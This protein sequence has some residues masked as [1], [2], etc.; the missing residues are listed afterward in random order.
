MTTRLLLVRDWGTIHLPRSLRFAGPKPGG[1]PAP[2]PSDRD[3]GGEEAAGP[4]SILLIEDDF[5]LA[6]MYR[7][8]L[9]HAGHK[10]NIAADGE[11][12]LRQLRG[13]AYDLVFLD[14]GLPK[15]DGLAVLEAIRA[16][17]AFE[18]LPVVMLTNYS[19]PELIERSR[20]LGIVEYIVKAETTPSQV[21]DRVREFRDSQGY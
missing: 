7:R 6:Q 3:R 19:E 11:D 4:I 16:E 17:D 12:G 20:K 18:Q 2:A 5:A 10:V 21:A 8:R 14:I 15:I 13:H 9:E 1:G